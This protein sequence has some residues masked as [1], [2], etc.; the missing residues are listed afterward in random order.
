MMDK[1]S[2]LIVEDSS[3]MRK[4]V[5]R[6]LRQAGLHIAQVFEASNGAE[7]LAALQKNRVDPESKL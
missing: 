2:A 6:S 3:G 1:L 5:E 4:I 7:A